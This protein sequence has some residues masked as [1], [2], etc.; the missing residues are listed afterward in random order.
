LVAANGGAVAL[1]ANF[2][3]RREEKQILLPQ[4]GIRMACHSERSEES[5]FGCGQG[6]R[7]STS[8]E[9]LRFLRRISAVI[10]WPRLAGIADFQLPIVDC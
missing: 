2:I 6:P 8:S 4:G 5:A 7:W 3:A 10:A 1:L 9:I